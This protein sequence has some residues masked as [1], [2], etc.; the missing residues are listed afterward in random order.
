MLPWLQD[1]VVPV[2]KMLVKPILAAII[3]WKGKRSGKVE[4]E[5]DLLREAVLREREA[6]DVEAHNLARSDAD[7]LDELRDEDSR[8]SP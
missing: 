2:L 1:V 6:K 4:A 5:R 3:F 7:V 8:G